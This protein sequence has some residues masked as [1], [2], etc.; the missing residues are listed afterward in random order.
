M[1]IWTRL[2]ALVLASCLA[3][4]CGA[5]L[6]KYDYSAEPDPRGSEFVLGVSDQLQISVWRHPE[7]SQNTTIPPGGVLA[8]PLLGEVRAEGRTT[9]EIRA[10]LQTRLAEFIKDESAVVTVQL[11]AINSYRFSV[12][13]EVMRSDV[14]SPRPYVTV[15]EAIALAGGLTRFAKRDQ[16]YIL[17]KGAKAG[18][19][20][21][22]IP[23]DYDA[24][25]KGGRHDM[26][27]VLMPGDIVH[28]P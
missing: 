4:G 27:I 21:R 24:I 23:V 11:V 22:R 10:E 16:I 25:V 8:L 17:R 2:P 7:L 18:E 15:T 13:G 5:S 1:H 26:N 14:M 6:P 20:P 19:E 28:V 3:Y 12:G 9:T